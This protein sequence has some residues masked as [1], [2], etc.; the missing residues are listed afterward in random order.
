MWT[1]RDG[2]KVDAPEPPPSGSYYEELGDF[3]GAAYSRNA[4][5]LGTAQEADFLWTALDLQAGDVVVDVGCGVGRHAHAFAQRGAHVVGIDISAGLLAAARQ[6]PSRAAFV[7]ADARTIP[8]ADGAADA[9][10]CLCQGGFGV[11][12]GGDREIV[13]EIARILRPAGRLALTAFSLPFA[14]RFLGP[15][16]AIDVTRGLVWS[17]AEVRGA[18]DERRTYDLWT[19]CYS[20][21]E[22]TNMLLTC[23][24][25]LEILSGIEPGAYGTQEPTLRHPEFLVL[26]RRAH[27]P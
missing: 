13:A 26:A 10:I 15:D 6:H 7:Q 11:T 24:F 2:R 27:Q 1:D 12:P 18:D 3:Q 17:P 5:A 20:P 19:S 23:G 4:F 21:A 9:V 16:D 22:L 8:L 25:D 14:A